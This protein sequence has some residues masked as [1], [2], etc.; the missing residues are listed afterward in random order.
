ME[1]YRDTTDCEVLGPIYHIVFLNRRA[2]AHTSIG[3]GILFFHS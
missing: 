2:L 3:L 1:G